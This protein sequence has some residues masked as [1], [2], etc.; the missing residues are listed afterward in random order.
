[1]QCRRS[2]QAG[3]KRGDGQSRRWNPVDGQELVPTILS[4]LCQ[5]VGIWHL[6]RPLHH[7]RL[8]RFGP[9]V[10]RCARH[11]GRYP[12]RRDG[13]SNERFAWSAGEWGD[14]QGRQRRRRPHPDNSAQVAEK[15]DAAR[16]DALHHF[17]GGLGHG[18]PAWR[19]RFVAAQSRF[20]VQKRHGEKGSFEFNRKPSGFGFSA[21]VLDTG[22]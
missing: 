22:T 19:N 10:G 13:L 15:A 1:M 20:G 2:S 5:P 17:V 9:R 11:R 8:F 18:G 14:G 7:S 3:L 16:A 4:D 6:L 12:P 21:Y